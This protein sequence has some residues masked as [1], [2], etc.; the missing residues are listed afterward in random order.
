ML[1]ID[2]YGIPDANGLGVTF[3]Y[4]VWE[5]LRH[6]H[7]YQRFFINITKPNNPYREGGRGANV[8]G[9]YFQQDQPCCPTAKAVPEP[10]LDLPL[11]GHCAWDVAHQRAIAPFAR[12]HIRLLPEIQAEVDSFRG[13][14]FRGSV[15]AIHARGSDKISE[16]QPM[17]PDRLVAWVNALRE[18]LKPT[19]IFLMTDD[20]FYHNLFGPMQPVS[21]TIPRSGLSLHHNPP[22]GPYMSGRWAVMDSWLA[23]S[24][25]WFAYTPSNTATI[26]LI[27][28]HH[29]EI[30]CLNAHCVL[31]SFLP[32]VDTVLG[33]GHKGA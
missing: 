24:A 7:L 32:R 9:Y 13:R 3:N 11:S 5:M 27:M 14:L 15:L 25:T 20:L 33:L 17:K 22:R 29:E 16:Y 23:A 18:R 21:L 10:D 4:V 30:I 26:P 1:E 6:R 28:G 19:T 8:W 12:E 2:D 31:E